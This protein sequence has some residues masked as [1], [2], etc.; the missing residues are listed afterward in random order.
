[1]KTVETAIAILRKGENLAYLVETYLTKT[2]T[3]IFLNDISAATICLFDAVQ[4]A[5]NS[6]S[7]E[8]AHQLIKEFEIALY[9]KTLL[10]SDPIFTEIKPDKDSLELILPPELTHYRDLQGIWI[11]NSH[12]EIFGLPKGSFAIV[13]R[14]KVERGDLAAI[15]ELADDS[16]RCGFYDADFG[17]V[18]LDA[19]GEPNLFDE[20]DIE[21][22]G[23][24]VG[25]C[26]SGKN[27]DGKMIIKLLTFD[28]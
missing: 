19:G 4:I 16:V 27:S 1:M 15:S 3:L 18:S 26:R 20:S 12:L 11:K 17:I 9:E 2:K 14:G 6:I 5:K 10:A 25:V 21:I 7:E 8:K 28:R 23:K 22:I 24:I 13:A